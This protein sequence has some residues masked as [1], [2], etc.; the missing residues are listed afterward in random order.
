METDGT[1]E[2]I[3]KKE[4]LQLTRERDKLRKVLDGVET[5]NKMPGAM[6][7]V[8]IKKESIAINEAL[9]LNIPIFAI[10]DTNCD[11]GPIDYLIPAGSLQQ[12]KPGQKTQTLCGTP[13]YL[14][15]ELV[16]SKG[17]DRASLGSARL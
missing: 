12:L 13:E 7:I 3:T 11:P 15:P 17:H 5:M 4:G 8:D 10:V 9:R 6:F 2:K 1:F 14:S 16:L